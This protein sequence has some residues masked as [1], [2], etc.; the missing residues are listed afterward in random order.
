MKE[1]ANTDVGGVRP[2]APKVGMAVFML[3]EVAFFGTLIMTYVYFLGAGGT[4]P[5]RHDLL[6]VAAIL[7]GTICLYASSFFVHRAIARER[8]SA[9]GRFLFWWGGTLVLGCVFVI[10]TVLEWADLMKHGL[11]PWS[12]SFGS[13]FYT[14]VGFHLLHVT[15]GV[16]LL[17]VVFAASLRGSSFRGKSLGRELISWYWHLVDAVWVVIFPLVYLVG[18]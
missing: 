12:S 6:S 3:S 2:P 17:A 9:H 8:E 16:V 10:G 5:A 1:I 7:P 18:R 14:L 11:L 13:T 15:L 4:G